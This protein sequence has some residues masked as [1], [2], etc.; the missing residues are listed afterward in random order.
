[1]RHESAAIFFLRDFPTARSTLDWAYR[2]L[3]S[4][5]HF[6]VARLDTGG[7][8]CVSRGE[9]LSRGT[10]RRRALDERESWAD[11]PL[12][13]Q[14]RGKSEGCDFPKNPLTSILS[15]FQGERRQLL[16]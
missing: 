15:P 9:R 12:P 2:E 11:S 6:D 14:G 3:L 5:H 16:G 1:V 4:K 7:H 8:P 13:F 10:T